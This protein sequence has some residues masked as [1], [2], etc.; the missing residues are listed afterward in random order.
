VSGRQGISLA[1]S[2]SPQ[3][4]YV[5]HSDGP[6][7]LQLDHGGSIDPCPF[8]DADGTLYLL[9]KSDDNAINRPAA[10]WAQHLDATGRALVGTATRLLT[11]D[12]RWEDPLIEAPALVMIDGKYFLFYSANWWESDRYG[13]G[14]ATGPAPLGPFSKITT[15][16]PWKGSSQGEAGPG[17]QD[18]CPHP[19]GGYWMVYHAWQPGRVGYANGGVRTVRVSTVQLVADV[20]QER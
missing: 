12:R 2:A 8:V 13:I 15:T 9:W 4:P 18:F 6:L 1:T 14:Y 11:Y 17:G 19:A 7:V 10:I 20:P 16:G 5:D 3:G